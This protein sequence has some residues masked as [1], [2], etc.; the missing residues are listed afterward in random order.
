MAALSGFRESYEKYKMSVE[1]VQNKKM[2]A[3]DPETVKLNLAVSQTM[4]RAF[5]ERCQTLLTSPVKK[6]T[7]KQLSSLSKLKS[8][9]K[10]IR[11]LQK[12]ENHTYL[13]P[14]LPFVP[15]VE[16]LKQGMS[17]SYTVRGY[18]YAFSATPCTKEAISR[19]SQV[20]VELPKALQPKSVQEESEA[21]IVAL[22]R[23][24]DV[25]TQAWMGSSIDL[26]CRRFNLLYSLRN[27]A[28]DKRASAEYQFQNVSC[29]S[30]TLSQEFSEITREINQFFESQ[31]SSLSEGIKAKAYLSEEDFSKQ[32]Q[33]LTGTYQKA[34]RSL[35]DK[36]FSKMSSGLPILQIHETN[37]SWV[38]TE[39]K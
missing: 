30:D 34:V 20:D 16:S 27:V 38:I 31:R 21:L 36:I 29:Y 14:K 33:S 12:R 19:L 28:D 23:M 37:A 32:W 6:L 11:H 25:F 35:Q 39:P 5:K 18:S 2:S 15:Y 4:Y 7:R 26:A 17:A 24:Q 13:T 10:E 8:K 3:Q 9:V 22:N 1:F